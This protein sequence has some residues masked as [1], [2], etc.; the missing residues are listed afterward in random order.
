MTS[1]MNVEAVIEMVDRMETSDW[2]GT[3][4]EERHWAQVARMLAKAFLGMERQVHRA[5]PGQEE[6]P[7]EYLPLPKV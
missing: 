6:L 5:F 1:K 7:S 2:E 3:T 4:R